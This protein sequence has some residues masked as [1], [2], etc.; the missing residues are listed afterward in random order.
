MALAV[1]AYDSPANSAPRGG[2]LTKLFMHNNLR[3]LL[4]RPCRHSASLSPT[5]TTAIP[6]CAA[7]TPFLYRALTKPLARYRCYPSAY[8]TNSLPDFC[9]PQAVTRLRWT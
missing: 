3:P 5:A 7:G 4:N 9:K 2:D 1:S 8:R 6:A